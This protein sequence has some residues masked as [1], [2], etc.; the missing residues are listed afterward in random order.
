MRIYVTGGTGF[1]GS[2][3][4]NELAKGKHNITVLARNPNK[5]PAL[6]KL[7]NVSVKKAGMYD[8]DDLK[9]AMVKPDALVHVALCW[10]DTGPDA[11]V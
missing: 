6:S 9:K 3:V 7:P 10:G 1:I 5:V 11:L 2:Y 8:H 4:V